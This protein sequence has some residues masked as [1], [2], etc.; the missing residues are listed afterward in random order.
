MVQECRAAVQWDNSTKRFPE[1]PQPL[2]LAPGVPAAVPAVAIPSA[3]AS[4]R[5]TEHTC[6]PAGGHEHAPCYVAG[7]LSQRRFAATVAISLMRSGTTFLP[8]LPGVAVRVHDALSPRIH[9]LCFS[10]LAVLAF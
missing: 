8:S 2:A 1:D 9:A 4:E 5:S 3:R 6:S 10:V 7:A